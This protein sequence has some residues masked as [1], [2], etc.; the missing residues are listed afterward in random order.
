MEEKKDYIK[1]ADVETKEIE[2][3]WFPY[4]PKGMVSINKVTRKVVKHLC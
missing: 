1:Y 3:L 4:L 2:W